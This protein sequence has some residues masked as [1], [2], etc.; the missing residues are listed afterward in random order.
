VLPAV[1][2]DAGC[3]FLDRDPRH[4]QLV[5]NY[6]RDGWCQLPKALEERRE[7]LQ[8]VRYYQ[9]RRWASSTGGCSAN[10]S[11]C[12]RDGRA[13]AENGPGGSCCRIRYFQVRP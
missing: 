5:L 7:L 10:H 4:F 3:I 1:K 9:V 13:A 12:C 11:E 6:L 8:E 2:D